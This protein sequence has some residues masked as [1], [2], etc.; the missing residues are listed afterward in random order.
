M[1]NIL[2]TLLSKYFIPVAF[3]GFCFKILVN[4]LDRLSYLR[5][6]IDKTSFNSTNYLII[7][8]VIDSPF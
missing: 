2:S 7:T 8:D 4:M 1:S 5:K 3:S 6:E